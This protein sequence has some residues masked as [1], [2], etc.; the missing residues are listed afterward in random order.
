MLPSHP[1][2]TSAVQSRHEVQQE[3]YTLP[4]KLEML[5]VVSLHDGL[6]V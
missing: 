6:E 4:Q 2:H 5:E 3:V 1:D